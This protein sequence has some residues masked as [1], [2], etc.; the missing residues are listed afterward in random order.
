MSVIS[1]IDIRAL[2][3]VQRR[4][5]KFILNDFLSNYHFRLVNVNLLP[6]VMI[7]N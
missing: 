2:E 7:L 5:T 6:L 3:N 1:V 4:A